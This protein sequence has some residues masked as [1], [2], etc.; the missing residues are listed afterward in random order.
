MDR[1][2]FLLKTSLS[3]KPSSVSTLLHL[4]LENL[5]VELTRLL[6]D[7][8]LDLL[9]FR[10]LLLQ[11]LVLNLPLGLELLSLCGGFGGL[12]LVLSRLV[13]LWLRL[14]IARLRGISWL[15]SILLDILLDF[16]LVLFRLFFIFRLL[17][18]G[19]LSLL[20]CL[21]IRIGENLSKRGTVALSSLTESRALEQLGSDGVL[22]NEGSKD[23]PAVECQSHQS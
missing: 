13:T 14:W 5:L 9:L 21:S 7:N 12:F 19:W 11:L 18:S 17:Y 23:E 4:V 16:F 22:G 1:L 2:S 20:T 6:L 15:C 3:S 10:S 8:L